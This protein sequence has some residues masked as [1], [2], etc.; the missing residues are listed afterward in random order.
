MSG[1]KFLVAEDADELLIRHAFERQTLDLLLVQCRYFGPESYYLCV[2]GHVQTLNQARSL[3]LHQ[4]RLDAFDQVWRLLLQYPIH[5]CLVVD[6]V[7]EHGVA[8]HGIGERS[9]A[10]VVHQV[11]WGLAKL[12]SNERHE[13]FNRLVRA[14]D[15]R[16]YKRLGSFE[17][18]LELTS[19]HALIIRIRMF[20]DQVHQCFLLGVDAESELQFPLLVELFEM[21]LVESYLLGQKP[22]KSP[23]TKPRHEVILSPLHR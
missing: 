7:L 18:G 19:C 6:E 23:E 1:H 2:V 14:H 12:V 13:E 5:S 3:R 17:D 16:V 21:R 9:E 22:V 8:H 15:L 10:E 11:E 20:G 4:T